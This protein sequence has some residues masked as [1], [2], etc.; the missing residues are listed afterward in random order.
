MANNCNFGDRNGIF[1]CLYAPHKSYRNRLELAVIICRL[2]TSMC[3]ECIHAEKRNKHRNGVRKRRGAMVIILSSLFDKMCN[4]AHVFFCSCI[5]HI[6]S[7]LKVA[8]AGI[9]IRER[10]NSQCRLLLNTAT[11]AVYV[12]REKNGL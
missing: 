5:Y 1:G 4:W 8:F 10:A 6:F 2:H 7:V 3:C 9:L 11:S 12:E